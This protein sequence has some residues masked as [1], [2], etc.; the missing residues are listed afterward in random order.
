MESGVSLKSVISQPFLFE[1]LFASFK[2]EKG[3]EDI[4][5]MTTQITPEYRSPREHHGS[6]PVMNTKRETL[7]NVLNRKVLQ[8][9]ITVAH[10]CLSTFLPPAPLMFFR[11]LA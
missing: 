5:P 9:I 4:C 11:E 3:K 8:L 2:R 6:L 7:P 1:S 10:S